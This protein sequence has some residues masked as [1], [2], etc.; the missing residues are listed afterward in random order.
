MTTFLYT[1]DKKSDSFHGMI[2]SPDSFSL[3][4]S[5]SK[6]KSAAIFFFS[7]RITLVASVKEKVLGVG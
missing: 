5:E 2:V 3:R 1:D 6:V 7:T 4:K